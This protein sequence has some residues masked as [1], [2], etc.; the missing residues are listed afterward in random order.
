VLVTDSDTSGMAEALALLLARC[1]RHDYRV[2]DNRE[3][4]VEFAEAPIGA[5]PCC[6]WPS[7]RSFCPIRDQSF[8][9]D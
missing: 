3:E 1:R 8:P 4:A 9:M 2:R 6:E 5:M 7:H